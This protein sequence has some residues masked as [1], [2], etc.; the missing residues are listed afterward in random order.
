MYVVPLFLG[1]V[2]VSLSIQSNQ[3]SMF[4]HAEFIFYC[5]LEPIGSSDQSRCVACTCFDL[6]LP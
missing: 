4:K 3:K 2:C 5:V 1:V 6:E